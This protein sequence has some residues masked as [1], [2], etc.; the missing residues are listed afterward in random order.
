MKLNKLIKI[1][2]SLGVISF[3]ILG[4]G[5]NVIYAATEKRAATIQHV[6]TLPKDDNSSEELEDWGF[7]LS[8]GQKNAPLYQILELEVNSD[9]TITDRIMEGD[10]RLYCLNAR[11]G[12]EW[13]GDTSLNINSRGKRSF[14]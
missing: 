13:R 2:L 14:I 6:R 10:S 1:V 9:G 12:E 7:A 3:I 11:V 5:Q 4:L 8:T